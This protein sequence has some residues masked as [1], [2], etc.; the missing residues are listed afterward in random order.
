MARLEVGDAVCVIRFPSLRAS[1][2]SSGGRGDQ[3]HGRGAALRRAG[4]RKGDRVAG[5][6]PNT[7]HAAIAMLASTAIGAVWA[8]CSPD[9]GA[10]GALDRF[11]QI[12]PKV[13]FAADA[14]FFKGKRINTDAKLAEIVAGLPDQLERVVL[15]NYTSAATVRI[16]TPLIKRVPVEHFEDFVGD[17]TAT[18]PAIEFEQ[19]GFDHPVYIMFS[20]G[21][22]IPNISDTRIFSRGFQLS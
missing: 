18:A 1:F 17:R 9:F 16:A 20:S 22:S 21:T 10:T 19:V 5:F 6:L 2:L 13:L 7:P 11:A 15:F 8:S 14:Y 4:L 3:G 12:Q